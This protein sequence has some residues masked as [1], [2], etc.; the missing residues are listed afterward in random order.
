MMPRKL[1]LPFALLCCACTTPPAP[2]NRVVARVGGAPAIRQH[3]AGAKTVD[4]NLDGISRPAI[5]LRPRSALRID[6]PEHTREVR[7]SLAVP[8][9]RQRAVSY[10][11]EALDPAERK[12][13]EIERYDLAPA[14][15]GWSNRSIA[16]AELEPAA[17]SLRFRVR[18]GEGTAPARPYVASILALGQATTP[19]PPNVLLISLDTLG[20]RYMGFYGNRVPVSPAL[21]RWFEKAFTFRRAYAPYGNTLVSHSSLFSGQYPR[22]HGRLI[23]KD[24]PAL[25]SLVGAFTAAGYRAEA[26]TENGFINSSFGFAVGFDRYD[27]GPN[28]L[29]R[30]L[31]PHGRTGAK[32]TFRRAADWLRQQG[33]DAP[34]LLFVHTYE[35]HS[36]YINSS[37]VS[38]KIASM[39]TPGD[40][41]N[42]APRSGTMITQYNEGTRELD[43]A[44]IARL[45][46]HYQGRIR[47]LDD[48]F[49]ALI[50]ALRESRLD[51]NTIV[52]VT[53]DHGEQ[54]GEYD[55]LG[56][57]MSLHGAVLQ[58][59][60]AFRWPG[61][62]EARRSQ[63]DVELVDVMP[64]VLDLAG[65]SVPATAE[66][67]SLAP[68]LLDKTGELADRPSFAEMI[69]ENAPCPDN[70]ERRE[71][72]SHSVTV[73][74]AGWK[75]IRTLGSTETRLIK[76]DTDANEKYDLSAKHPDRVAQLSFLIDEYMSGARRDPA[77][78]R[79][80]ELSE[81]ISDDLRER[82]RAL[83]YLE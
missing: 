79:A 2:E 80:N 66:G 83:G 62:I 27:N 47:D 7:F 68:L 53:S 37:E 8:K 56:H 25:D 65:L 72:L 14:A 71:C 15:E 61:R 38:Q 44:D 5:A 30:H 40:R 64:T 43:E 46:A 33:T 41:R 60:L 63:L 36:P 9:Q 11:V 16:V 51:Q 50:Q 26:I 42:L 20:A 69:V 78:I 6:L 3:P 24:L 19:S 31:G 81:E 23:G 4:L 13:R 29:I 12:W 75:L 73:R 74:L 58:V 39:I 21:D 54:F 59:P 67:R 32:E 52:V 48:S 77:D 10:R 28:E 82:L 49:A 1:A 17:R 76:L 34:F 70:P 57:G 18:L 35:V 22:T 45:S 55:R